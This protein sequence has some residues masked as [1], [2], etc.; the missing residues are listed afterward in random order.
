MKRTLSLMLIIGLVVSSG[1]SKKEEVKEVYVE[2]SYNVYSDAEMAPP[3]IC[4][5]VDPSRGETYGDVVE[6]PFVE[7]ALENTSTFSID[8]DT[9]SYAN[10]RDMLQ[11]KQ[12]P[13]KESVRIEE[14]INY[15]DYDY[16]APVGDDPFSLTLQT[17]DSPWS[18]G[19]IIA[20]IG[21][22][23][24]T[25]ERD[26]LPPSNIVMLIDV[27]GSMQ[28]HNKLP[29]LKKAFGELTT[30][31]TTKDKVSLV[32]YAGAA[33]IVLDGAEGSDNDAIMSALNRLEAGGSTAGGEGIE[34]AYRIAETHFIEGGNNRVILASDGDFNVGISSVEDL[35][36]LIEKKRES[37]VFLSVVGFGRGNIRDDVM[38]GLADKGNGNYSYIDSYKESKK[39]FGTEFVGTLFTIAKDVKIQ[40]NFN[41]DLVSDYRLIGYEN[42]MLENDDFTD[43]TKDAGELGVGHEVTALYELRLKDGVD[44]SNVNLFDV[45]LRYKEPTENKS[46]AAAANE[47]IQYIPYTD[48][49]ADFKWSLVVAEFGL[50]LK[51]SSYKGSANTEN[52]LNGATE[53]LKTK[54]DEHKAEFVSMVNDYDYMVKEGIVTQ[55][56]ED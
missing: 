28:D 43:D 5:V 44:K 45:D 31:L 51:E 42:R 13:P 1:C 9:A 29:L 55:T 33:G 47:S 11:G 40:V 16:K 26:L 53:V 36:N 20:Q 48:L 23:G 39:V 49:D 7:T 8:V 56:V 52:I 25:I 22:Q 41:N 38:E 46:K 54:Y 4:V 37:G 32:V 21:V 19:S 50:L 24:E 17:T 6:N 18:E 15:F 14:M 34:L 30:H 10:V 3:D 2:E 27:S 12:M 35:E